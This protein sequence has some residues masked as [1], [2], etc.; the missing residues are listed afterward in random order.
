MIVN[1]KKYL[2]VLLVCFD[3]IIY[4]VVCMMLRGVTILTNIMFF[5]ILRLGYYCILFFC[6]LCGVIGNMVLYEVS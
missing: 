4:I 6:Y 2:K 5:V 1:Q 3:N